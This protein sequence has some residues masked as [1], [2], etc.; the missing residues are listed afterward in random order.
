MIDQSSIVIIGASGQ[1]SLALQSQFP[2]ARIASSKELD[3]S[4]S[5]AVQ[6]YDWTG[7]THILNAGA[8]TNVDE[9]ETADGRI[10]A[11]KIN[12]VGARNLAE[13]AVK[14]DM[15]LVHVSTD[16]VFDGLQNPHTENEPLSPLG[17]Y[18]QSKAAGDIAVSL[19]PKHYIIR[20]SWVI[21]D[22]KNFVRTMLSLGERGIAPTVVADQIGRLTFTSELARAIDHLLTHLSPYGTYNV[23]NGGGIASWAEITREIFR[24]SGYDLQVTDT[25]TADYFASKPN[26]APRP[27]HSVFSLSKLESTGFKSHV[28]LDDLTSYI[29]SEKEHA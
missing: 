23:S 19:V 9:A 2:Q 1:L 28:W 7:I 24:L 4:D 3:I 21:G 6:H 29:K 20:T 26:V 13:A 11:W 27:L 17:V 12:A 10:A 18:G 15:T 5:E 16:Y 14:H 25:T 22:G 8:Y